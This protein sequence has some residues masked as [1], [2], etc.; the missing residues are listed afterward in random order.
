M[1]ALLLGTVFSFTFSTWTYCYVKLSIPRCPTFT[2]G[3]NTSTRSLNV[4]LELRTKG[5]IF[6]AVMTSEKYMNTRARG[7][8]D[9]WG[10]NVPGRLVFFTGRTNQTN[11]IDMPVIQLDVEDNAYPPQRKALTM[12]QYVYENV[13]ERYEWFIRAD[14]DVY[15]K[16]DRLATYLRRLDSTDDMVVGQPGIGKKDELGL[17]GL[18]ERDNFCIGGPGIVMTSNVLRKMGPHLHHCINK[19]ASYHEDAEV[20]RC[21]RRFGG[22]M[23]PWAFEVSSE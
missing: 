6:V 4:K 10:K 7:V 8:W 17:L 11:W 19:T 15:M 2:R 14:D 18:G 16:T 12:L 22:V 9:T 3:A 21:I 1:C 13:L 5:L 20:G 23:C